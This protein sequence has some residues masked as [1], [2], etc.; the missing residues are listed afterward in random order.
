[1]P[2]EALYVDMTCSVTGTEADS[3]SSES[4]APGVVFTISASGDRLLAG[5]IMDKD[6]IRRDCCLEKVEL[7]GALKLAFSAFHV[8]LGAT[9]SEPWLSCLSVCNGKYVNAFT[10]VCYLT[11][12]ILCTLSIREPRQAT[13]MRVHEKNM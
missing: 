10:F 12:D 7:S 5:I 2:V 3:D 8:L 1:V 9:K 11:M 6:S 13:L 4:E